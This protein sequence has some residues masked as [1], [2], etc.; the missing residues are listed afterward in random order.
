MTGSDTDLRMKA[1]AAF[2]AFVMVTSVF[3]GTVALSGNVAAAQTSIDDVRVTEGLT[4]RADDPGE[5]LTVEIDVQTDGN[6]AVT[7]TYN[8]DISELKSAGVDFSSITNGDVVGSSASGTVNS[9]NYDDAND[10]VVVSYDDDAAS[11]VETISVTIGDSNAGTTSTLEGNQLGTS[12]VS[13]GASYTVS[14]Q[15]DAGSFNSVS[16]SS[17][18]IDAADINIGSLVGSGTVDLGST[19]SVGV[20]SLTYDS[21]TVPVTTS[22]VEATV[23]V[24]RPLGLSN[25]TVSVSGSPLAPSYT[26]TAK[27]DHDITVSAGALTDGTAAS[28]AQSTTSTSAFTGT[29]YRLELDTPGDEIAGTDTVLYNSQQAVEGTVYR[30]TASVNTQV[31]ADDTTITYEITDPNSNTVAT[32]DTG[33][34]QFSVSESWDASTTVNGVERLD[35]L[36]YGVSVTDGSQTDVSAVSEESFLTQL[37]IDFEIN[38]Q[39]TGDSPVSSVTPTFDETVQISGTVQDGSG[40]PISGYRVAIKPYDQTNSLVTDE[41][42]TTTTGNNG[43]FSF[44]A[45]LPEGVQNPQVDQVVGAAGSPQLGFHLGTHQGEA[46]DVKD[47]DAQDGVSPDNPPHPFVRYQLQPT[48]PQDANIEITQASGNAINFQDTY[49]IKATDADGNGLSNARIVVT[50]AFDDGTVSS[51][52]AGTVNPGWSTQQAT[53]D[54]D[55]DASNEITAFAVETDGTGVAEVSLEPIQSQITAN[56]TYEETS[57][58]DAGEVATYTVEA[59]AQNGQFDTYT[60]PDVAG[61]QSYSVGAADP[62]NINN[63]DIID[64]VNDDGTYSTADSIFTDAGPE[65]VEVLPVQGA[66]ETRIEAGDRLGKDTFSNLAGMTT[67]EVSFS[68]ADE[69]GSAIRPSD[70]S[71]LRLTGAGVNATLVDSDDDDVFD[72]PADE[73]GIVSAQEGTPS[74]GDYRIVIQPTQVTEPDEQFTLEVDTEDDAP[75]TRSE[76]TD[77]LDITEF[78]VDGESAD[79][80]NGSTTVDLSAVVQT[81]DDIPVNNGRVRLSQDR[82]QSGQVQPVALGDVDG[83]QSTTNIN[84]GAYTF[85]SLDIGPRGIDVDNDGIGEQVSQL[86][87]TAYQYNDT[88]SD[89]SVN[90]EN[91]EVTS[92]AVDTLDISLAEN[93]QVDYNESVAYTGNNE[94]STYTLT[95]GVEYEE[96]EFTLTDQNGNA[97]NLTDGIGQEVNTL[98]DL[99]SDGLVYLETTD[100]S[101]NS[102][103]LQIAFDDA[104]SDPANGTYVISDIDRAVGGTNVDSTDAAI[105]DDD[106]FVIN[107]PPTQTDA[108]PQQFQ[109]VVE[110]PDRSQ[111]TTTDTG[112]LEAAD[113][114]VNGE[115]VG[116][117]GNNVPNATTSFGGLSHDQTDTFNSNFSDINTTTIGISRTYRV[118]ATVTTALGTPLNGSEF[119]QVRVDSTGAVGGNINYDTVSGTNGV[120]V[121]SSTEVEINNEDGFFQFD[122]EPTADTDNDGVLSPSFEV[123][124]QT[125]VGNTPTGQTDTTG[126]PPGQNPIVEV[127]DRS[128]AELPTSDDG[129]E[130]LAQDVENRLRVEAFPASEN[131]FVLPD[132]QA[133][134]FD[135]PKAENTAGTTTTL[136]GDVVTGDYEQGQL[137]FIRVTPTGTGNAILGLTNNIQGAGSPGTIVRDTDGNLV[138]F[139]VLSSNLQVD[140]TLSASSVEAGETVTVTLTQRATG[141]TLPAN[142]RVSLV[143]PDGT[144]VT[145][146]LTN[147]DGEA[148]LAVPANASTSGTFTVETRPAGYEPNS[149]DLSVTTP[150]A[151]ATVTFDDVTV[152][153]NTTTVTVDSVTLDDGGFVVIHDSNISSDGAIPSVIGASAYLEPGTTENVTV[154][155]ERPITSNETLIA[156]AHRDT[157]GNEV[158]DFE[159]SGGANDTPYTFGGQAITDSASITVSATGGDDDVAEQYD[160]NNDGQINIG[161][162]RTAINDFAAGNLGINEVRTLINYWADGTAV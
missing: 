49:T 94:N 89:G 90:L 10:Q 83:R 81:P 85:S 162:V 121:Q 74:N 71:A 64:E 1:R 17:Q 29:G 44:T 109:L 21:D 130:I 9:V 26:V 120:S 69:T 116:V 67:Y 54:L 40:N 158:F 119:N 53:E 159:T 143:N 28:N 154:E 139:D 142:T 111:K 107:S 124:A 37:D 95:R 60:E 112:V 136:S 13:P 56:V 145:T 22:N 47:T 23:S 114:Q 152:Q 133:F 126:T 18:T 156:M 30:T 118:N 19:L 134:G 20:S 135:D 147:A 6:A 97:V 96:I 75:V 58:I 68:L 87:F 129:D 101:G 128:G 59:D 86:S 78:Q 100:N 98:D 113:A 137:G 12:G 105:E 117:T 122:Y 70:L 39:S 77:G 14:V 62:V 46:A 160:S 61:T 57:P 51:A 16:S 34:G 115:V 138:H 63:F 2:L 110:T 11:G 140:I 24:G 106:S 161:E 55:A 5:A 141:Q 146:A 48:Q 45:Q 148:E 108:A 102:Q 15:D 127:Y 25:Q 31:V 66:G 36:S 52:G 131:D 149:V 3:G 33:N 125:N 4:V 151:P 84:N 8:I 144:Q 38:G 65:V 157:N 72:S 35:G 99:S 42:G 92:A 73:T 79:A 153:N 132:G 150:E 155:L 93:L 7:K 80:V 88:D 76:E 103:Q 123:E 43:Q 104:A 27:G 91:N 50:G 41:P 82:F 32:D